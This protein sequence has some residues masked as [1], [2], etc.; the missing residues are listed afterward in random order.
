LKKQH[1]SPFRHMTNDALIKI[2]GIFEQKNLKNTIKSL[3]Q[4]GYQKEV[5][6]EF[7]KGFYKDNYYPE[8]RDIIFLG[9]ENG[10]QVLNHPEIQKVSFLKGSK[11]QVEK[12]EAEIV[13]REIYLFPNGLHFFSIE[14]KSLDLDLN[15][16][17]DLMFS[18]RLFNSKILDSLGEEQI[19]VRWIEQHCLAGIQ[20]ASTPQKS[21]KVDAYSGSK[22][23]LFTVL[24]LDEKNNGIDDAE[25]DHLL[26]DF[27]S[28][29]KIGS[30]KED[31]YFAPSPEYFYELLN[32]KISVFK[33]YSILPLFDT[34]TTIGQDVLKFREAWSQTYYRIYLYNLFIKFNLF[35]YNVEKDE[36]G[37]K[38]RDHFESFLNT[39]NISHISYNFLPNLIYHGHRKSL[40]ID[41]E[42]E[43]FQ[44]RINRISQ[45]IQEEQQNRAN[46]LLGIVG[47]FTSISSV[48]PILQ[49]LEE[50]RNS[51]QIGMLTFYIPTVLLALILSIPILGYLFPSMKQKIIKKWKNRKEMK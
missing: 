42:L 47:I 22:F 15:Y 20:I 13:N 3:L 25:R 36:D 16:L 12:R 32:N 33:N 46:T 26:Y 23:K 14:L 17:S 51:Y 21:V 28:V 29:A 24:D 44:E 5:I 19:W 45:S 43:K 48:D 11:D 49:F 9:G 39:Y 27:G 4:K 2:T 37:I 1:P 34:F 6:P 18:A 31:S 7:S 38:T 50:Y 40:Q 35:R 10:V 41:E 8:F 30:S